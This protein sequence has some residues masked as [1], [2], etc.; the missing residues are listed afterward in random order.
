MSNLVMTRPGLMPIIATPP[1]FHTPLWTPGQPAYLDD[2]A[3]RFHLDLSQQGQGNQFLSHDRIGHVV[4]NINATATGQGAWS[5]NGVTSC[6]TVPSHPALL[7][8]G[9]FTLLGWVWSDDWTIPNERHTIMRVA[10]GCGLSIN[11]NG[12]ICM[13]YYD[14][15]GWQA[16]W[17]GS[18]VVPVNRWN[19]V[20]GLW[21]G[22][23][24]RV[25]LN[26]LPDATTTA[27]TVAPVMFG[28]ITIGSNSTVTER[29]RLMM[30]MTNYL[31]RALSPQEVAEAYWQ[32]KG[33]FGG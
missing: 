16:Q 25:Y 7:V 9:P 17:A 27:T 10:T 31:S 21:D 30:A 26:G 24:I 5:F 2:P 33:R 19:H 3:L 23:R 8:A 20:V 32:T 11:T 14:G 28:G 12:T 1:R 18:S 4:T 6:L 15:G 29:F 22:S 13:F